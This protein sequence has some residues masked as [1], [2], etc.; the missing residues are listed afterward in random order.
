M[1]ELTTKG[2]VE[3]AAIAHP[4]DEFYARSGLELP[5]IKRVL[6]SEVPEPYR[7]LLVHQSDMTST[8]ENFHGDRVHLHVV[9]R[10][11]R[12]GNYFREVV[13]QLDDSDKP[14]EFGAIKINLDL[15]PAAAQKEILKER[16]PLGRILKE[17]GMEYRSQ[18]QAFLRIASDATI[19]DLLKLR[20]THLLYGRRNALFDPRERSLA[21]IVEILPPVQKP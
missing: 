12:N 1:P 7:A 9:G 4:L 13:L 5:P 17:S 6:A 3:M 2:T 8:L 18:P 11:R 10:D 20:E 14:V 21:E 16:H 15:F 19:N